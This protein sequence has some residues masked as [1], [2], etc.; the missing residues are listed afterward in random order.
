MLEIH[1]A[2]I[3]EVELVE[4]VRNSYR[5]QSIY[6]IC[7]DNDLIPFKVSSAF[8]LTATQAR[9]LNIS[10]FYDILHSTG[11]DIPDHILDDLDLAKKW[12]NDWK[13]QKNN[14]DNSKSTDYSNPYSS[15]YQHVF[16]NY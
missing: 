9:L 4:I 16:K 3:Q 12:Y 6:A 11:E 8:E 15:K 13:E 1:L 14:K 2:K 7:R 5:W 10:S